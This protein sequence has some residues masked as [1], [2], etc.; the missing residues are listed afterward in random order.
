MDKISNQLGN[1]IRQY[2]KQRELTQETLA[3]NAG[4]NVSF[5]GDVERVIKK[6]SVESLEK[7]LRALGVSFRDFFDYEAEIRPLQDCSALE[8]LSLELQSRSNNEVEMIYLIVKR[9]L[10]YNDRNLNN[11]P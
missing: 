8:K 1:R 3:L 4:I 6:P 7:L 2:R 9:I 10:E 5:L 11:T